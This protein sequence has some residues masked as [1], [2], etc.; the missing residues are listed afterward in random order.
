LNAAL[1]A[2]VHHKQRRTAGRNAMTGS[3]F[4]GRVANIDISVE[5]DDAIFTAPDETTRRMD[6][7]SAHDR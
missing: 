2:R 5:G 6:Q 1:A 3:I 4:S 7:V